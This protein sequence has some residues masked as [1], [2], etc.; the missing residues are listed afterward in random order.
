M[1]IISSWIIVYLLNN[2][3]I[4]SY[5]NINQD[6]FVWTVLFDGYEYYIHWLGLL[7]PVAGEYIV[8]GGIGTSLSLWL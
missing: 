4:F 8:G 1:I 6:V 5:I 7:F 2:V 3:W